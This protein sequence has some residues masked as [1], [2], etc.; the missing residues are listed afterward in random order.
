MDGELLKAQSSDDN[1]APNRIP[2]SVQFE[3]MFPYYLSIGMTEKQYWDKDCLL[4]KAYREAEKIRRERMNQRA[5]LQGM[6]FY[7]ALSRIAPVLQAF[8]KKGTKAKP[9]VDEPYSLTKESSESRKEKTT[10]QKGL[11]YMQAFMLQ[12]NKKYTGRV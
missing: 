2:Y 7:D 5:W 11:A 9:Y 1:S 8:A 3:K 4:V 10:E 12:N 6:Y